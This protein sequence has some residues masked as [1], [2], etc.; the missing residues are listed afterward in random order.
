MRRSTLRLYRRQVSS[1][2]KWGKKDNFQF[3]IFNFQFK[4][5]SIER[6]ASFWWAL[7]G[8]TKWSG[9]SVAVWAQRVCGAHSVTKWRSSSADAA[10]VF[11]FFCIKAK[12][13][14]RSWVFGTFGSSQKYQYRTLLSHPS[15][16]IAEYKRDRAV[17]EG[18]KNKSEMGYLLYIGRTSHSNKRESEI[19][20]TKIENDS[21]WFC[22]K[23]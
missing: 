15:Q 22:R 3:S 7:S 16:K 4:K 10:L 2:D 13:R 14:I 6:P 12:E 21:C 23:T 5:L 8:G 11:W 19:N 17:C 18:Y 1:M 9:R 20:P